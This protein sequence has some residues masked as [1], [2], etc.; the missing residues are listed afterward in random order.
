MSDQPARVLVPRVLVIGGSGTLG[1]ELC[2]ALKRDGAQLALTYCSAEARAQE[3]GTEVEASAVLQLDVRQAGTIRATVDAAVEAL[4]G[5]DALVFCAGV[6][7]T[8]PARE[9]TTLDQ[10]QEQPSLA[11]IDEAAWDAML[12]VNTKGPFFAVQAAEPHLRAA[13]GGNVVL[14]GSVDGTKALP[15]PMHYAV[16]KGA[17]DAMARAFGK[18]LGAA[19][20]RT[21]VVS[22]GILVDGLSRT[23]ETR[24]LD[25]YEKH[26]GLKRRGE[27]REA[28]D[29]IS[30]FA[31]RNTYVTG[32][33]V[34]LDGAL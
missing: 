19:G 24:L 26:C 14:V 7:V 31:L 13:G 27:L 6:G 28:A 12:A 3:L 4:G 29:V 30:W 8:T 5:L 17:L 20:I 2:R 9:G 16:S 15:G 10:P 25:E 32:R 21:T 23:I 18:H 1:V 22:P 33:T 11:E 34:L